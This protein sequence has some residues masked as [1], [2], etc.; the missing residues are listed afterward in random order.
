MEMDKELHSAYFI[1]QPCLQANRM[2]RGEHVDLFESESSPSNTGC[3]RA[4]GLAAYRLLLSCPETIP[5]LFDGCV[6]ST[7]GLIDNAMYEQ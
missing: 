3:P 1:R 5:R 6:S 4:H 7:S 2:A